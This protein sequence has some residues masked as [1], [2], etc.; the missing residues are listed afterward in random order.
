[1]DQISSRKCIEMGEACY[2]LLHV[3]Q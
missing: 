2:F 1:M 3:Y